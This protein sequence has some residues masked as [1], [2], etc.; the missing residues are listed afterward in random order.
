VYE[1]T[2]Q[3]LQ[4]KGNYVNITGGIVWLILAIVNA[5]HVGFIMDGNG[6]WAQKKGLH[7]SLGIKREQKC[8]VKSPDIARI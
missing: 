7:D 4:R 2:Q 3:L 6:R 1:L 8:F 5:V